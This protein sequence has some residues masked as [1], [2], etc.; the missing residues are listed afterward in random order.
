MKKIPDNATIVFKGLYHDVYHWDQVTFDGSTAIFEA[1]KKRDSV[2]V[3]AVVGNR[4][5]LNNEEQPHRPAF[6][7]LPGGV[8]ESNITFL[9]NAKRELLEETG[10]ASDDWEEWFV[11]DPIDHI[12]FEWKNHFFIAKDCKKIADQKL[13]AG[14]KIETQLISFEE[15]LELRNNP[16]F[17]TKDLSPILEKASSK[18]EERQ[19]LQELLGITQ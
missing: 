5:I 4:I 17:R 12:K 1:I 16:L 19:V 10:Y 11:S 7:A 2:T 15:F 3:V 9:E 8:T 13:D 6:C 18:P 14:E